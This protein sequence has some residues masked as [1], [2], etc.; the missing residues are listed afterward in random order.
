[1]NRRRP[2]TSGRK[3][4]GAFPKWDCI[5]AGQRKSTRTAGPS[6]ARPFSRP[7]PPA[8]R[9]D[10]PALSP[11]LT[12]R[13]TE[14]DSP[15]EGTR[16]EPFGP[17]RRDRYFKDRLRAPLPDFPLRESRRERDTETDQNA[18]TFRGTEWFKSI[19]LQ[20]T[21]RLSPA[22]LSKAENLG[23]PRGCGRL[24]WRLGRQRRAGCFEIAPTGGNISVG[25]YSSTAVPLMGSARMPR[26][27]PIKSGPSP[28]RSCGRSLCSD[29]LKQSRARSAERA[30]QAAGVSARGVSLA[31][32]RAAAAH[33][34]SPG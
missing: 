34:G 4:A 23:F 26:P 14:T 8:N 15:L 9:R 20:R 2:G 3:R 7:N 25:P 19:S 1:M 27:V 18:G 10:G 21:V 17:A 24:G 13:T 28:A 33:R 16:F 22:P 30:R 11:A 31:S 29:G 6:L 12:E 32:D 5:N